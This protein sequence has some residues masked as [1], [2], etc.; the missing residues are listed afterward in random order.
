MYLAERLVS[1]IETLCRDGSAWRDAL[2]VRAA[3]GSESE[4]IDLGG[5]LMSQ[6]RLQHLQAAIEE[7]RVTDIDGCHAALQQ[8]AAAYGEDEWAWVCQAYR[9]QYDLD[10]ATASPTVLHAAAERLL[11][12]RGEFLELVLV[13]ANKE[14]EG[15]SRVGYGTHGTDEAADADF[16]AVR[17]NAETNDFVRGIREEIAA[18][19][20]RVARFKETVARRISERP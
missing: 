10:L 11:A 14:F 13:D 18:L 12:H 17:G 3:C 5:Q 6:T 1:R 7:Q 16:T 20:G 4:W 9:S 8:I 19:S 15:P 2:R